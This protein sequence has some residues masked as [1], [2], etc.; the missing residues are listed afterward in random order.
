MC[1]HILSA[2]LL[3]LVHTVLFIFWS[4]QYLIAYKASLYCFLKDIT[5]QVGLA[6]T[7]FQTVLKISWSLFSLW[8]LTSKHFLFPTL[9]WHYFFRLPLMVDMFPTV[10]FEMRKIP[11]DYTS[12]IWV[13]NHLAAWEPRLQLT[14]MQSQLFSIFFQPT[15]SPQQ[16]LSYSAL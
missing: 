6:A 7:C 15:N 5:Q 10:V 11:T 3:V 16:N 13:G 9:F 12:W 14:Q 1:T 4:V 8:K 2:C